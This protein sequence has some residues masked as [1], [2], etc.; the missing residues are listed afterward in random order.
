M[1]LARSAPP[2]QAWGSGGKSKNFDPK[3]RA[4]GGQVVKA[5]EDALDKYFASIGFPSRP[6]GPSPRRSKMSRKK[7]QTSDADI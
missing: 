1:A 5:R 4:D 3:L 7:K 2:L 6:V